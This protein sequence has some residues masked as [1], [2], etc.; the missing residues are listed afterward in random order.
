MSLE[1]Q[2]INAICKDKDIS[3]AF[4]E[5]IDDFFTA[6]GDVWSG[7]KS[8]YAKYREVP[9]ASVLA[10]KFKDFDVIETNEPAQAYVDKLR[11]NFL[12]QS[13]E[14]VLRSNSVDLDKGVA[15]PQILEKIQ[16]ELSALTKYSALVKDVNVT[17][18]DLAEKY[19]TDLKIKAAS[20]GGSQGI[21]TGFEVIDRS[22]H[23][24]MAGGHLIVM[25]G[26]PGKMKS[27][28]SERIGVNVWRQG[29]RVMVISMEMNAEA[30]RD[31]IYTLMGEGQFSMSSLSRGEIDVDDFRTYG[32][33]NISEKSDFIII[34]PEGIA[35]MTPNV[36]QSKVDKYR[37]DL[38]IVDYHQLM[39]DNKK[40][41]ATTERNMNLSRELKLLAV[42]N[43]IPV[44]DIV[45]AT[46]SDLSDRDDPPMLSQVAWSKQIEYDAD[47]ALAVHKQDDIANPAIVEVVSRKMRHGNDFVMYLVW[48]VNLGTIE[49]KFD[50]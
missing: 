6:Y 34:S 47:M 31:R 38:L 27:W 11:N 4:A 37:P 20:L 18:I 9:A 22:Y 46:A 40:T 50:L 5:N 8:Y 43:N 10:E 2:T 23:T 35:D 30:M 49:V 19:Y 41:A 3:A 17:D 32:K 14:S 28:F 13:I 16:A 12:R 24:H 42:R 26:W 1:A 29:F 36:I 7:L 21:P 15:S 45:S 33:K 39:M 44:I 25:I 48:D